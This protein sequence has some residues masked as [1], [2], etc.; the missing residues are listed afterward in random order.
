MNVRLW[1]RGFSTVEVIVAILVFSVGILGMSASMTVAA[2]YM[3]SSYLETQLRTQMQGKMEELLAKGRNRLGSGLHR[4]GQLRIEWKL[5]EGDPAEL[6]VVASQSLGGR[7]L[8][9]TLATLVATR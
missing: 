6:R 3:R 2:W 7:E 9:D 1:S 4:Q 8:A 5:G